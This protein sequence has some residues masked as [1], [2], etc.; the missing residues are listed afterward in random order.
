MERDVSV[1]K[2]TYVYKGDPC[3]RKET[4]VHKITY[5]YTKRAGKETYQTLNPFHQI[6]RRT[7]MKRDLYIWKETCVYGK[8]PICMKRDL[9]I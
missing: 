3:I 6:K 8:R 7:Y 5:I 1:W 2:E 4:Y 9:C